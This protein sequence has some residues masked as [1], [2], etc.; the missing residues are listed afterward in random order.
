MT[1]EPNQ[2]ARFV[3]AALDAECSEDEAVF[4]RVLKKIVEAKPKPK[5]KNVKHG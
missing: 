5:K 1:K 4:D 2:K 3:K